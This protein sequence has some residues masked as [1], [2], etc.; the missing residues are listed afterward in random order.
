M[1][2]LVEEVGKV[3]LVALAADAANG[4][5]AVAADTFEQAIDKIRQGIVGKTNQAMHVQAQ[6]IPTDGAGDAEVWPLIQRSVQAGQEVRL[7]HI[8]RLGGRQEC[9]HIVSDG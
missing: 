8:R 1:V 5:E 3:I 9:H 2:D 4:V 6:I 7:V